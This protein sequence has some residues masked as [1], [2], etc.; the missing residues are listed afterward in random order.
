MHQSDRWFER[1]EDRL[2]ALAIRRGAGTVALNSR[3]GGSGL[4]A[5]PP[6][7]LIQIIVFRR[8][9][10]QCTTFAKNYAPHSRRN[11]H[12][13]EDMGSYL[14]FNLANFDTV[15]LLTPVTPAA[16]KWVAE[17]LPDSLIRWGAASQSRR[18][19]SRWSCRR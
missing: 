11:R 18:A 7:Q 12:L 6:P 14:D 9:Q 10:L 19:T 2:G 1:A 5:G 16:N 13:E 3:R 8:R 15:A 4:I 17:H